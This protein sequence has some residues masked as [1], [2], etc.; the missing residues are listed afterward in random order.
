MT[1]TLQETLTIAVQHHRAGHL[2]LAEQ[3]Y[4]QILEVEPSEPRAWH[5]LGVAS[6]QPRAA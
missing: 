1:S 3:L 5:L 6:V 2:Q 4:R